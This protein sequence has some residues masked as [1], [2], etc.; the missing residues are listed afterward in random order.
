M[1]KPNGFFGDVSQHDYQYLQLHQIKILSLCIFF[2]CGSSGPFLEENDLFANTCLCLSESLRT[3][4]IT[5]QW[6]QHFSGEEPAVTTCNLLNPTLLWP[7]WKDLQ[8]LSNPDFSHQGFGSCPCPD[9][10]H[11]LSRPPVSCAVPSN[12]CCAISFPLNTIH[13]P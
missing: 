5:L 11:F 6:P 13:F 8:H 12:L 10:Y 4:V 9:P 1:W 7:D 3:S 2:Y